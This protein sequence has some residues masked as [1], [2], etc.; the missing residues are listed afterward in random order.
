MSDILYP[1]SIEG[2]V[3]DDYDNEDDI[4][5]EALKRDTPWVWG[6]SYDL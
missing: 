4:D 6:S 1:D 3:E 5:Y 2:A